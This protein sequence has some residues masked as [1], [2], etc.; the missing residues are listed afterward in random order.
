MH[1]KSD[2]YQMRAESVCCAAS[3]SGNRQSMNENDVKKKGKGRAH[4]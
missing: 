4:A 1:Q 2:K 3:A